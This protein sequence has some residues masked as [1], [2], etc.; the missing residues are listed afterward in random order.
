MS[1]TTFRATISDE[2]FDWLQDFKDNNDLMNN[3][4]VLHYFMKLA[5]NKKNNLREFNDLS[6]IRKQQRFTKEQLQS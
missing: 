4:Q 1:K 2:D 5:K 3:T 6:D